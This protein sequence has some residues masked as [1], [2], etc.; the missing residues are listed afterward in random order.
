MWTDSKGRRQNEEC[1]IGENVESG[2]L[3]NGPGCRG[4]RLEGGYAGGGTTDYADGHGW[5]DRAVEIKFL[6]VRDLISG[7]AVIACDFHDALLE[8]WTGGKDRPAI[9][10]KLRLDRG[11]RSQRRGCLEIRFQVARVIGLCASV[12]VQ[13]RSADIPVCGC[14]GL[15][16]PQVLIAKNIVELESSANPQAGK[17]ALPGPCLALPV[18]G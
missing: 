2:I 4:L 13:A 9:R 5:R 1:R 8:R 17:P 11:N 3:A 14:W 12:R 6:T 16:V 18:G 10:A 7:C 15:S